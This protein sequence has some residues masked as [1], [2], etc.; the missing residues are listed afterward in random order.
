MN[1]FLNFILSLFSFYFQ[2]NILSID[3]NSIKSLIANSENDSNACY[4]LAEHFLKKTSI[5]E[6]KKSIP[7][8]EKGASKGHLS[9]MY[10]LGVMYSSGNLVKK[11]V[12]KAFE[13]FK[14]AADHGLKK[15]QFNTGIMYI[16]FDPLVPRDIKLGIKYM[17]LA[18]DQGELTAQ[19]RLG[20]IYYEGFLAKKDLNVAAKYFE[21]GV[22][23]DSII[24]NYYYG[25]LMFKGE[26]G[27]KQNIE[28]S[29]KL[30]TKAAD[31]NL[32]KAVLFLASE[33]YSEDS[34]LGQDL[35]KAL[36][37]YKKGADLGLPFC[38]RMV[39]AVTRKINQA[40]K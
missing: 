13:L 14:K 24:A 11:D 25:L 37:W 38:S 34:L 32:D 31:S 20:L 6:K 30:I 17:K 19:E 12:K 3:D 9:C 7:W 8:F 29:L 28:E 4:E 36:K 33:Y 35:N 26:G 39:D 23:K 15:A 18:A 40:K 5:E 10:E 21:A 16:H 27:V 1:I 22:K 2:V